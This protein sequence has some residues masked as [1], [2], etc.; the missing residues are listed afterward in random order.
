MGL[1]THLTAASASEP[2][3]AAPGLPKWSFFQVMAWSNASFRMETAVTNK[4]LLQ[5][6]LDLKNEDQEAGLDNN[7]KNEM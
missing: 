2:L 4:A 5:R 6:K 1:S 3:P 7:I